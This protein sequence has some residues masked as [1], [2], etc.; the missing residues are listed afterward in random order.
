MREEEK[1]RQ[2]AEMGKD[3]ESTM[4]LTLEST[5]MEVIRVVVFEVKTFT[6]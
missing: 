4:E 3:P 5:M 6:I 1:R 2:R